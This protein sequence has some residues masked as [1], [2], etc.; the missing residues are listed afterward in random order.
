MAIQLKNKLMSAIKASEIM[1]NFVAASYSS[2]TFFRTKGRRHNRIGYTGS[3]LKKTEIRIT[4]SNNTIMISPK[5]RLT[6]C[7][8]TI[9]GNNCKIV[10]DRNC[11]LKNTELWLEDNGSAIYIGNTT[12]M[13]GGH[14]AATE[15]KTIRISNDCMF[16]H[17][18][19]I[20]NGDSHSIFLQDSDQRINPAKDVLIGTHVWLGADVKVMKGSVISDGAIVA[21]GAIVTGIV[22]PK[23]IYAGNPA[24]KIKEEIYWDRKRI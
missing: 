19:E 18:I 5:N 7:K 3:L 15:G 9:N 1:L 12:S 22:E 8:L 23:S 11:T 17:G 10:I 14:I 6:N 4:G 16:A 21:T 24:K 2:S 20:R 13:E